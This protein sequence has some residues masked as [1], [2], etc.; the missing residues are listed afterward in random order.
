MR[1]IILLNNF[2]LD[3]LNIANQKDRRKISSVE[4][5]KVGVID[6]KGHDYFDA[7]QQAIS[8][9]GAVTVTEYYTA[10]TNTGSDALTLADGVFV[11]QLKKVQMIVDPGTDSTLTPV[12]FADGATITFADAGDFCILRWNGTGWRAIELGNGAD[13]ATAPVIA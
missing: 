4:I 12:N 11:G 5:P 9:A 2:I 6:I 10:V 1:T 7:V 13:G 8:G 3:K